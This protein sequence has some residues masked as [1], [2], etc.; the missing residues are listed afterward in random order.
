MKRKA[1]EHVPEKTRTPRGPL[2]DALPGREEEDP[3][4]PGGQKPEPVS[5]RPIVGS[6]TPDDYPLSDRRDSRPDEKGMDRPR[7]GKRS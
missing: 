7:D 2:G 4:T 3:R 1:G 5:K 6:V